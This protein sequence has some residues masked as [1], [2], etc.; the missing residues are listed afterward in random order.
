MSSSPATSPI[1]RCRPSSARPPP[2]CAALAPGGALSLVPGN[3]D[4]L[5]PVR[6][7]RGPRPLG[8]LDPQRRRAGRS[9]TASAALALIGLNSACRPRRCWPAAASARRSSSGWSRCS[10]AEG[11]AGRLRIVALHHP[12]AAGAIGW[13]KAL[14]DR[15]ALAAVLRRAGAELVLHGHA[16]DARL[17][18]LPGPREPIPCLCVPSSSALPSA[19][20]QG[21]RWHRLALAG[22]AP[23]GG[24]RSRCGAGRP[25]QQ[26][27]VAGARYTLCLPRAAAPRPEAASGP[28]RRGPKIG[29]EEKTDHGQ[30]HRSEVR[31][32]RHPDRPDRLLDRAAAAQAADLRLAGAGLPRAG[33]GVRRGQRPGLRRAARG[34]RQGRGGAARLRRLRADQLPDAD[35]GRPGRALPRHPALQRQPQ[36]RRARLRRCRLARPAGAR[37]GGGARRGGDRQPGGAPA[38]RL[39]GGARD[40]D[41]RRSRPRPHDLGERLCSPSIGSTATRCACSSV[42]WRWCW[43]RC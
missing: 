2:G 19:W 40:A 10:S 9:S 31:R 20:D 29:A 5:V 22:R 39:A 34:R 7:G 8:R 42:R 4:A 30:R 33:A 18:A 28:E 25:T 14:A 36:L 41:P 38:R 24:S 32:S 12:P 13:R 6:R 35:D 26:A 15:P 16:R 23:S 37:A 3:H 43:R 27:F 11:A 1:S 17:D 21:A